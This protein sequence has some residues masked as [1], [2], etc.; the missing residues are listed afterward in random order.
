MSLHLY[1]RYHGFYRLKIYH[2][3]LATTHPIKVANALDL[4]LKNEE[5]L[6][7]DT[8]LPAQFVR[9]DEV[10]KRVR[11]VRREEGLDGMRVIIREEVAKELES[12][13]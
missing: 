9:L 8:V 4:A 11:F 1:G 12:R 10:E 13:R 2:I 7:F 6:S 3:A 5:G